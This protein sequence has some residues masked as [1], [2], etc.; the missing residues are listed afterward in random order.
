MTSYQTGG[1]ML[2]GNDLL[3]VV[4][5]LNPEERAKSEKKNQMLV[6][7]LEF[8][9]YNMAKNDCNAVA[10]EVFTELKTEIEEQF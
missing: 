5:N 1:P 4:K 6:E 3:Q 10:I 8:Y 7:A 9:I 2:T